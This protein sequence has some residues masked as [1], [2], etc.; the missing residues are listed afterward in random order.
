MDSGHWWNGR[1]GR[2]A[3]RD[4]FVRPADEGGQVELRRGG[5]GGRSRSRTFASKTEAAGWVLTVLLETDGGW[6]EVDASRRPMVA[7]PSRPATGCGRAGNTKI[8]RKVDSYWLSA[9]RAGRPIG[10]QVSCGTIV[11]TPT[12]PVIP[13]RHGS[14]Q[15]REKRL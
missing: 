13:T 12:N 9:S 1:W 14:R 7:T 6:R 5:E 10:A 11:V 3:R 4:V 8:G 15:M 2:L